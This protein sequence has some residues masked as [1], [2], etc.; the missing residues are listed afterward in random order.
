MR[1]VRLPPSPGP[2]TTPGRT[3]K[4]DRPVPPRCQA[5]SRY[6]KAGVEDLQVA[7]FGHVRDGNRVKLVAR[8]PPTRLPTDPIRSDAKQ[9]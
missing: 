5:E 8:V 3:I 1:R 2:K 7:V 9:K 4:S 6:R